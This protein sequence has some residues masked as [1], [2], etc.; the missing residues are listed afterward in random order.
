MHGSEDELGRATF[1]AQFN[2][3]PHPQQVIYTALH[4]DY[5]EGFVFDEQNIWPSETKCGEIIVKRLLAG[6]R[7]HYG[8]LEHPQITFNCGFFP[9]SVMQQART[10]RIGC[11]LSGNTKVRFGYSSLSQEE[12]YYEETIEKLANLWHYGSKNQQTSQDA[13]YMQESISSRTIFTLD[14]KTNQ[15][16]FA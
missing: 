14:T 11:C 8:C 16:V 13:K 10:H 9:H 4:Q 3:T 12:K 2:K 15:I 5:S 7:G 1:W 6:D